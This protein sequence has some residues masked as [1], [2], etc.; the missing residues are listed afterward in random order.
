[1]VGTA[2]VRFSYGWERPVRTECIIDSS[3]SACAVENR[4]RHENTA[5]ARNG[6]LSESMWWSSKAV[7]AGR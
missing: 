2:A 7:V 5:R 6:H 4:F 3:A 1:M